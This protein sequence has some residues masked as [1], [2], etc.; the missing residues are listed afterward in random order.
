MR[1]GPGRPFKATCGGE[2]VGKERR[3]ACEPFGPRRM[4]K[5]I[6]W[7]LQRLEKVSATCI[8]HAR[9]SQRARSFGGPKK[10]K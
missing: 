2:R 5:E 3:L 10:K 1:L 9:A 7:E 8:A 4:T 6:V